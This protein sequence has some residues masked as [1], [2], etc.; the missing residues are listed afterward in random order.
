MRVFI[1]GATGLI[2]RH[3]TQKLLDNHHQVTVLSRD[4]DRARKL[5]GE[6]VSYCSS[7]DD[8]TAINRM[9]AVINL[10]GEPIADKRWTTRQKRR[11]CQSRWKI[12][13]RLSVLIKN[14]PYPPSVFISGSAIGFYGAQADNIVTEETRPH[15]EFT[16]QLCERWEAYAK[17]AK[18]PA[19]RV[20]LLR[21]AVVL[22]TSGGALPKILTPFKLGFGGVIGSGKQYMAWI[23]IQDMVDGIYFL[24]TTPDLHGPFNMAAP[25]PVTNYEFSH[26]LARQLKRPCFMPIPALLLRIIMGESATVVIHGQRAEPARLAE[27]GFTFSHDNIAGALADL[28]T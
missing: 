27:A 28:L 26:T 24:L 22:S 16:H 20:C 23:H 11:L 19:T 8:P 9:D 25:N 1:T 21:T 13:E 6:Q 12:T 17:Q 10:A 3:L 14:S 15:R 2:G 18:S 5:F 4:I 7:L